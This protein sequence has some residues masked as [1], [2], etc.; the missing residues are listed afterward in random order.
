MARRWEKKKNIFRQYQQCRETYQ[1]YDTQQVK[2]VLNSSVWL[3]YSYF[4]YKIKAYRLSW[5]TNI[6]M[7]WVFFIPP[8]FVKIIWMVSLLK[9]QF[10]QL[11]GKKILIGTYLLSRR[12]HCF[13]NCCRFFP[14]VIFECFCTTKQKSVHFHC[15]GLAG[16]ISNVK[17]Q[18][19]KKKIKPIL[20]TWMDTCGG[21]WEN[22]KWPFE[23]AHYCLIILWV[24]H[25]II[26]KGANFSGELLWQQRH[27]NI[28]WQIMWQCVWQMAYIKASKQNT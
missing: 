9:A 12:G 8:V 17:S 25:G 18:E 11:K 14:N 10:V 24:F 7:W 26:N 13:W 22:M 6:V 16:A 3:K 19:K 20:S 21:K 23:P 27:K 15:S 2:I 5:N 1:E 4:V 28:T